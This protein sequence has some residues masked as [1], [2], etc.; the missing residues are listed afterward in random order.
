MRLVWPTKL[1]TIEIP[2]RGD[3]SS[4][5]L[6]DVFPSGEAQNASSMA[7]NSQPQ[8]APPAKFSVTAFLNQLVEGFKNLVTPSKASNSSFHPFMLPEQ[9][10]W[11]EQV[12]TYAESPFEKELFDLKKK[13]NDYVVSKAWAKGIQSN[14]PLVR[15]AALALLKNYLAYTTLNNTDTLSAH[16]QMKLMLFFP[17]LTEGPLGKALLYES[18]IKIPLAQFLEFGEALQRDFAMLS[19]IAQALILKQMME[20]RKTLEKEKALDEKD[21]AAWKKLLKSLVISFYTSQE[22]AL[23]QVLTE[24]EKIRLGYLKVQPVEDAYQK[25]LEEIERRYRLKL[26]QLKK[27][28][29]QKVAEAEEEKLRRIEMVYDSVENNLM[30]GLSDLKINIEDIVAG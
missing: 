24:Q 3:G 14:D 29:T 25:E 13:P 30:A 16:T 15:D 28:R 26:R 8:T 2:V 4:T 18:I 23:A 7:N 6:S 1:P 21:Y 12:E 19:P 10:H 27:R 9:K 22:E 20:Y 5:L 11:K 17:H